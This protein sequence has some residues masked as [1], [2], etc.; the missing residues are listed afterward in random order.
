MVASDSADASRIGADVLTAGGNAFDA[1]VATSLALTVTRPQS[2]GIGGGGFLVAYV[3]AEQRFIALDFRE[4]APSGAT[5]EH[6]AQRTAADPDGPPPSVYGASAAG[7]PGLVAGLDEIHSRF[8]SRP[9]KSLVKPAIELAKR[10]PVVDP[11]FIAARTDALSDYERW[12]ALKQR[13]RA[14]LEQL[15][16]D[17]LG[18]AG[19][20]WPRPDLARTLRLLAELGPKA[21]YEGEI[22]EAIVA[23]VAADGGTMT[24]A[25]L[26]GYRVRERSPL[27][28]S[29]GE[30][31]IV[32]MP[33]PSSGGVC[34]AE[35]LQIVS[36]AGERSDLDWPQ[37]RP[38]VLVEASKHAFADRARWLGDPDFAAIP[39][40]RLLSA[41]HAQE[42]ARRIAARQTRPLEQYGLSDATAEAGAAEP[43]EDGGT[44]HFCVVDAAGNVVSLTETVN[45]Y[46]GSLLMVGP[47]GIL[48][49][50]QMDD[51]LIR[52][53]AKNMFGLEQG[54]VNLVSPGK[55]PLSSMSPTIVLRDRRPVLALGASG[56]PRIITSVLHVMLNVVEGR[57]LEE[58]MTAVRYHHQWKPD[59]IVFDRRPEEK[60]VADLRARGHEL[61]DDRDGGIVQAIQILP[62]GTLVG[63]SDPGKGGAPAGVR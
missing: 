42:M 11:H 13:C 8:G 63:A 17:E 16:P 32:S 22:A 46:F 45:G 6:F 14:L 57:P 29:Y 50:N 4:T 56:G 59:R 35:M 21:F 3:A 54:A 48:L 19:G 5:P 36:A 1:A 10:G 34:L 53:G 55:R 18:A 41:G 60:L 25:D 20:R 28:F 27:R 40:D 61:S 44:S 58:A 30:F 2:T 47:Y 38:H 9:W 51:F 26:R 15:R 24:L 62:D 31:E 39:L 33:P 43:V 12:P 7:V 52:P 23:A 37:C 49:N